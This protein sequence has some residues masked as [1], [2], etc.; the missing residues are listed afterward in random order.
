MKIRYGVF[1]INLLILI[2]AASLDAA[3]ARN[4]KPAAI[5][6]PTIV[7]VH[8]AWGGSWA[9]RHVEALLRGK[10]STS[11]D[12]NSPAWVSVCT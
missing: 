3:N 9:F 11:T 8:G 4:S 12:H 7:I 6:K 2:L 10:G 1:A 5:T